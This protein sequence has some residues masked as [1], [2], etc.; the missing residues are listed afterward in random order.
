MATRNPFDAELEA[1]LAALAAHDAPPERV[2][3]IRLLCLAA[4]ARRRQRA[5]TGRQA[6]PWGWRLEVALATGLA[7]LY[8]A[9]A[10]ERVLVILR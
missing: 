5:E 2:E 10:I 7:T 6:T 4:L 1:G 8:L 9:S 3:R